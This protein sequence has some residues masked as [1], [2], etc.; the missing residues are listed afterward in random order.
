MQRNR[1]SQWL[2]TDRL[3]CAYAATPSSVGFSLNISQ[4]GVR[5]ALRHQPIE[6]VGERGR[7]VR[8][9]TVEDL[10]LLQQEKGEIGGGFARLRE[11]CDQGMAEVDFENWLGAE[12]TIGPRQ[13]PFKLSVGAMTAGDKT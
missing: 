11:A 10:R 5:E 7:I 3:A 9:F 6:T 1:A 4:L 12:A 13:Q 2:V 8:Q